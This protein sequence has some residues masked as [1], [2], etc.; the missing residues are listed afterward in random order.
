MSH[1][2][3]CCYFVV[4]VSSP[5]LCQLIVTGLCHTLH[6][7]V[8]LFLHFF[9]VFFLSVLFCVCLYFVRSC[10]PLL[11]LLLF[12]VLLLLSSGL[13]SLWYS[14][15]GGVGGGEGATTG[16]PL[17]KLSEAQFR[18]AREVFWCTDSTF[19]TFKLQIIEMNQTLNEK[20]GF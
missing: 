2:C 13:F 3:C 5:R 19:T 10:L 8:C 18:W 9:Y 20:E 4:V 14:Q 17:P 12:L 16:I 11:L 6:L 15:I 1:C 7:F